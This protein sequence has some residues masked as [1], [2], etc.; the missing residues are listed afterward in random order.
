[1]ISANQPQFQQNIC[2]ILIHQFRVL[3]ADL[4]DW[5]YFVELYLRRN[6][7]K[8][9]NFDVIKI[10]F[11]T[12]NVKRQLYLLF[13]VKTVKMIKLSTILKS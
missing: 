9:C 3:N 13:L 12:S 7:K 10:S 8:K 5:N 11:R 1:M 6:N 2:S 4:V